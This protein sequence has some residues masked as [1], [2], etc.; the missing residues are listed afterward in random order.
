MFPT[1]SISYNCPAGPEDIIRDDE[2]GFLVPLGKVEE[3]ATKLKMLMESEE[4]R[5][6]FEMNAVS[7]RSKYSME[8]IGESFLISCFN[9]LSK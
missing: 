7:D 4:L 1:A 3:Y 9:Y 8:N 6:R 2:N 5:T